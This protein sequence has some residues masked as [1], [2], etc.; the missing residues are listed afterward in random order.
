[1]FSGVSQ[2]FDTRS[3]CVCVLIFHC[4]CLSIQHGPRYQA[5]FV[6]KHLFMCCMHPHL[7]FSLSNLDNVVLPLV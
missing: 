7:A 6:H 3:V 5:T 1:M 2:H 4:G